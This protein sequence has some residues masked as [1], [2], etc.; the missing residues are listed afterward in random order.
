MVAVSRAMVTN[1]INWLRR[2]SL[3]FPC[4]ISETSLYLCL[5]VFIRVS[6]FAFFHSFAGTRL[7]EDPQIHRQASGKRPAHDSFPF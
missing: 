7:Q 2:F 3:F 5:S 4:T 1:K 6:D